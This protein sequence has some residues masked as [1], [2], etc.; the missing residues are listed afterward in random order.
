MNA[1]PLA[2]RGP[3]GRNVSRLRD[4]LRTCR[5][6]PRACG[7]NRASGERGFCGLGAEVR[8]CR[9]LP[10]HGEEPPLSGSRGAGTLFLASCNLRCRF[11]QNH[12]ISWE[13]AGRPVAA[14]ELAQDMLTLAAEGCHNIEPVTPTPHLPGLVEAILLARERG[15]SL[16]IVW[17]C[18]GYE[19][20]DALRLLEG[21]VDIYLPDFKFGLAS[22]GD[23]CAGTPDYPEQALRAVGE[24]VRQAGETLELEGALARRGILVRHLVLPGRLD[25]SLAALDLLRRHCGPALPLSLL[26]Q[27]TPVPAV[28]GDARLGRRITEEE[29]G[30]VV[31]H[32]LDLGFE[33]IFTQEVNEHH[34]APDFE[35]EAPFA[36]ERGA[37]DRPRG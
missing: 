23:A 2:T 1:P 7:V 33:W 12:Q 25:N 18:G 20:P 11:C 4:L 26:A 34:L 3:R 27:Y 10:H 14:E 5:L 9:A 16:P 8:L 21:V 29:Y 22:C 31:Q 28:A 35:R 24:M 37:G 15:L 19:N 6:C 13:A 36:W 30:L 32:A 17:N